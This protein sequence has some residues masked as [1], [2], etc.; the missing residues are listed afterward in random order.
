[1]LCENCGKRPATF[2]FT[3]IVN[4]QKTE[5]HLCE[6]CAREKGEFLPMS[7]DAFSIHHLLSGMMHDLSQ[8]PA[9]SSGERLSCPS[10]GWTYEDLIQ[11]SRFGCSECY[12]TFRAQLRP[13]FRRLH[14]SEAHTG[15]VPRRGEERLSKRRKIE[16]LKKELEQKIAEEAFEEAAKLRDKL[17]A[18][19]KEA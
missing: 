18:L 11:T 10:C 3:K 17:R 19:E 8:R 16:A 7:K 1:M 12:D 2:H 4:G 6:E 15:K 9:V 14:G 5:M 13:I